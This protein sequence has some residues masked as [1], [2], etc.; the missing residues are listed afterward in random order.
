MKKNGLLTFLFA[1]IPGAG[2][3]YYGYMQRGLSMISLFCGCFLLGMLTGPLIVT[4]IIVWMYS[5]FD[6][7]DLI[8][9]LAAGEPKE[10]G[11]LLIGNFAD[12]K[13]L[14]PGHNKLIGWGLILVG[15]WA[16]YDNLI[17]PILENILYTLGVSAPWYLVQRTLPTVVVAVLLVGAGLWMLGLHPRKKPEDLPPYPHDDNV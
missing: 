9:Y 12:L 7:Y 10:D 1:C 4:S 13:R 14:V 11:L 6:T 5:F 17:S 16:L 2:Q 15:L 8:R 3:M